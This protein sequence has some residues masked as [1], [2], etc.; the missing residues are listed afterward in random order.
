MKNT[1]TTEPFSASI[2]WWQMAYSKISIHATQYLWCSD[3]VITVLVTEKREMEKYNDFIYW[4][5]TYMQIKPTKWSHMTNTELSYSTDVTLC[6]TFFWQERCVC[7][8]FHPPPP[9]SISRCAFGSNHS[10]ESVWL[11][12]WHIWAPHFF[13]ILPC[14]TAKVWSGCSG[15]RPEQLCSSPA[16]SSGRTEIWALS[17]SLQNIHLVVC[18]LFC[19]AFAGCLGSQFSCRLIEIVLQDLVIFF[20]FHVPLY[21][22]NPSRAVDEKHPQSITLLPLQVSGIK[23]PQ[24]GSKVP[25]AS[26]R[27]HEPRTV[28]TV[29]NS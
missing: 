12:G 20:C 26:F 9:I 23:Y 15:I 4:I 1:M 16:T 18:D 29:S 13:S 19:A 7:I 28:D 3:S 25:I 5:S 10:P 21:L 6:F 14:R 11:S 22:C 24:D 2:L 27:N 8:I 17:W